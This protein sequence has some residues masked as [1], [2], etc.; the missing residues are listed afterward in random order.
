MNKFSNSK[1]TS[2][3]FY[4]FISLLIQGYKQS[5][6]IIN[7]I[8]IASITFFTLSCGKVE[9]PDEIVTNEEEEIII[10]EIP[11]KSKER[12]RMHMKSLDFFYDELVG[13]IDRQDWAKIR[14]YAM[15]MKNTSPVILT[16]KRKDELPQDFVM[17]DTKFH[18]H[19]LALVEASQAREMV[20]MNIEFENVKQTCDDCH[21]KFKKKDA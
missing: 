12:F 10:P 6:L 20:K 14:K 19:T 7:V 8:I 15:E 13:S 5:F 1:K 4:P 11:Y 16:G 17:L 3:C 9:M 18:L 2:K 21:V